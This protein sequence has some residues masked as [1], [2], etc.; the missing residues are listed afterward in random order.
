MLAARYIGDRTISVV[1]SDS[2]PPRAGEVR[3]EVAYTGICGTDLHILHGFMDARVTMPAVLGHEMAGRLVEIG[4][5]VDGW[6]VGDPVTVMPLVWCGRCPACLAGNTHVCQRLEF[7]GIDSPGS[8]Q[9]S[10]T[11]PATTLVGLPADLPLDRA[12]LVEP[13]AVAVHDV[14][15]AELRAG[16]QCL[17]VGGGPIGL[18]IA[19][20]ARTEGAEVLVLE[21]NPNRREIAEELGLRVVDPAA[22]DLPQ[23]LQTWTGDAGVTVA[24]EVSGSQSGL[25]TAVEALSV[26]GRLVV[27]AI[28]TQP[29]PVNL[30]RLFW[31][32]LSIIGARVYTRADFETAV[33]LI[34]E[35]D[36]PAERLISTIVPISN[37]AAAFAALETGSGVLKALVDCRNEKA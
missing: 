22:E 36:V 15:R 2:R 16:E 12:A 18:L 13:T 28:H 37:A 23:L 11:V 29:R 31:R 32:E 26:R 27:V 34:A 33:R 7:V 1:A 10:W 21:V 20:V 14:R 6:A 24:F 3:L 17:I 25:D 8:M 5:G 30:H 35:G 9:G 4:R 19:L